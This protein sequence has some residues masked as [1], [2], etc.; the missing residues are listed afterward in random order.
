MSLFWQS[1]LTVGSGFGFLAPGF[2]LMG[3]GMGFIMSP[4]S[5][6]A[7]NAVD[8]T[9]AGVAGG[10]LSMSRMIGGTL[11]IAV[12]GALI[13]NPADPAGYVASLGDG[14]LVGSVVAAVGALVAWTLVS[15]DV[16]GSPA[17]VVPA[18]EAATPAEL[19]E[20]VGA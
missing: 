13:G 6:A 8:R 3:I 17:P 14:L 7:M 15:P 10:I 20:P 18:G 2:V 12:L 4:M 9:K 5:T 19:R 16:A 1:F 11:G